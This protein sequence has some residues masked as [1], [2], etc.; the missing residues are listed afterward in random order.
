MI[1]CFKCTF[2]YGIETQIPKPDTVLIPVPFDKL[3]NIQWAS[4]SDHM[5]ST[6]GVYKAY[7]GTTEN[8][9]IL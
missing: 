8:V 4:D 9:K 5:V 2:S 1:L 6:C 7:K 3:N